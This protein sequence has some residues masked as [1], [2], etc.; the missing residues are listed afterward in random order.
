M[1][2]LFSFSFLFTLQLY[3]PAFSHGYKMEDLD[4]QDLQVLP[5]MN[6]VCLTENC[7]SQAA[8]CLGNSECRS[9][10]ACASKCFI[11]VW[12]N[13]TTSEKVHVHQHMC[14]QLQGTGVRE[15][16]E[17]CKFTQLHGIPTH[18]QPV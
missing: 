1:K 5:K 13:D 4:L 12:D 2:S 18:P 17:V 10:V 16:Y 7:L 9:A 3:C 8:E 6:I 11:N 14:I 15:F